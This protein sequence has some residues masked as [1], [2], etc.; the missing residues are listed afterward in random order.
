MWSLFTLSLLAA[1]TAA[2]SVI[3]LF[4]STVEAIV[5]GGRSLLDRCHF[6]DTTD[7]SSITDECPFDPT[8][9][10]VSALVCATDAEIKG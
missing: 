2:V 5:H 4:V 7:Y 1:L 8:R 9:I 10:Y 3:G 6:P